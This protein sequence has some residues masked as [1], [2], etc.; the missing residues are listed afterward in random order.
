MSK[1]WMNFIRSGNPNGPNLPNWKT[2]QSDF[3]I[4]F[5]DSFQGKTGLYKDILVVLSN[6]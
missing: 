1:Y 4:E 3:S 6:E 5:G 2:Y